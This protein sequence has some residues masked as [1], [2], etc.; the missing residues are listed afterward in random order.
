MLTAMSPKRGE[1]RCCAW[2][3]VTSVMQCCIILVQYIHNTFSSSVKFVFVMH[4]KENKTTWKK[5]TQILCVSHTPRFD[6]CCIYAY[7][8]T[9]MSHV[10][11]TFWIDLWKLSVQN[12]KCQ[13]ADNSTVVANSCMHIFIVT[14]KLCLSSLLLGVA[15]CLDE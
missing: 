14:L 12:V 11:F 4:I 15:A 8:W 1:Y 6:C 7:V 2:L 13:C 3:L 10:T 9:V 5:T